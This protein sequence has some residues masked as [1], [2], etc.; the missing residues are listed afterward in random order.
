[1]EVGVDVV[2][3]ELRGRRQAEVEEGRLGRGQLV[4]EAAPVGRLGGCRSIIRIL[5]QV[6]ATVL[7]LLLRIQSQ[8]SVVITVHSVGAVRSQPE[9]Y[10]SGIV[11][12]ECK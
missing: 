6:A 7:L 4:G 12:Q 5:L 3:L 11:F 8:V 9:F 2:V 1:M 10:V